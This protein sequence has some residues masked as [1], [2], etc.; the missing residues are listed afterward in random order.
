VPLLQQQRHWGGV[1][2]KLRGTQVWG[3]LRPVY[4]VRGLLRQQGSTPAVLYQA[5]LSCQLPA[6]ALPTY[7]LPSVCSAL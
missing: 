7:L 5:W 3:A 2:L 1:H 4:Q 6:S